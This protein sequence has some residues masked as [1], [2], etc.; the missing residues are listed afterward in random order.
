[1]ADYIIDR[2]LPEAVRS[3]CNEL[4]FAC[5]SFSDDWIIR[6]QHN[7]QQK[8][9]FGYSFSVNSQ[10]SAQIANDKVA[11]YQ[12][13]DNS[14]IAAMPHNLIRPEIINQ[15]YVTHLQSVLAEGDIVLKPL[16]GTG[17]YEISRHHSLQGAL[18][19]IA[20]TTRPDWCVAP[21]ADIANEQ[22]VFMLDGETMLSYKKTEPPTIDGVTYFNL[23]KGAHAVI[24]PPTQTE[25]DL[26]Y[27]SMAALGL[28]TG[29]V[30]IVTLTDGTV[31]VVEVNSGVML[32]RFMRQSEENKLI[33][34]AVYRKIIAKM[35]E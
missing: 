4:D 1:M 20:E 12:I 22:R 29:A 19:A 17:G 2:W 23:G 11:C 35:M 32:E 24:T 6:V 16:S 18:D 7:D 13:L 28:R 15:E 21:Y 27:Q 25:Q 9:I 26:A 10:S 33:G 3:A 30:D 8:F 14:G 34:Y 5:D 31:Q